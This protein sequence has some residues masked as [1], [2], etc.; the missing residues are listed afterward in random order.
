VRGLS[1]APMLGVG[2]QGGGFQL[3]GRGGE[4]ER[5]L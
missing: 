1:M 3:R 4:L 2:G 5:E